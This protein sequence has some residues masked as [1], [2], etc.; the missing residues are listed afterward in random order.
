MTQL[1]AAYDISE[2]G[3]SHSSEA[4]RRGIYRVVESVCT[5]LLDTPEDCL[6]SLTAV[7]ASA[8]AETYLERAGCS[9]DTRTSRAQLHRRGV[10]H[11]LTAIRDRSRSFTED[12]SN[13]SVARRAARWIVARSL[14]AQ[15]RIARVLPAF[16]PEKF[17]VF[18][19]PALIPIPSYIR[20]ARRPA[21]FLTLYDLIPLHHPQLAP[22]SLPI[23]RRALASLGPREFAICISQYVKD[24]ACE[25]LGLDPARV[26]VAALAADPAQFHRSV[27]P[28]QIAE[29]R[30][31]CGLPADGTPYLLS[32]CAH[33]KRKNIPH[34]VRCF[35]RLRREEPNLK[36]LKLVLI[37]YLRDE[38]RQPLV[39]LINELKLN[40][41]VLLTGFVEDRDLAPLYSDALAFVFPSVA[42]GFGLPPLEAMQCGTPVICSH[43]TSLPE[44]VGTAGLLIDP[45]DED[46]LCDAMSRICRDESLRNDLSRRGAERAQL[47]SWERCAADHVAAYRAAVRIR[48]S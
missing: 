26:F 37:G 28:G 27:E 23:L 7:E 24:D 40:E 35:D 2:L 32:L 20:T 1:K 31:R 9:K 8:S 30:Q 21:S 29:A 25:Y 15:N 22:G 11:S 46:A 42:E 39:A 44:V 41:H 17:D 16:D 33:E 5:A 6:I 10:H 38:F 45:T 14:G 48:H 18:H 47:F 43:R 3:M 19:S 12:I 4:A 34:L 13:R 36:P